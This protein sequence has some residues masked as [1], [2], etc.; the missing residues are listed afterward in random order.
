MTKVEAQ[1]ECNSRSMTLASS[2]DVLEARKLGYEI[3][4]C[5][6]MD[7]DVIGFVL[8]QYA[9]WC[10]GWFSEGIM[11]CHWLSTGNAFCKLG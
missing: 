10:L 7:D 2:A 9:G 4:S 6:W 1:A 8:Q 5:G 3:C 11:T